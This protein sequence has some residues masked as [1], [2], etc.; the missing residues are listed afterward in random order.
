MA[1]KGTALSA[2]A[3]AL[4][5]NVAVAAATT[6]LP[7]CT[8]AHAHYHLSSQPAFKLSFVSIGKRDGWISDLA[9]ELKTSTG[10]T[11]WFLFDEGS[12]RYINL[13]ST[14]DVNLEGWEP[15]TD[16]NGIRPLGEM[17]YFAWTRD[18]RFDESVPVSATLAPERIFLPDLTDAMWYRASPR[19]GL[20]QGVFVLDGCR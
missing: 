17:H 8:V 2:M 16:A 18:Y 3:L 6:V 11:Y 19:Q 7:S 1:H 14:T 5:A 12:A 13:I 20:S 9:L 4:C 10:P 15:P